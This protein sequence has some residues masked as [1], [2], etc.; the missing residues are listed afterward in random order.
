MSDKISNWYDAK[1]QNIFTVSH[2]SCNVDIVTEYRQLQQGKCV[3]G[4]GSDGSN[5]QVDALYGVISMQGGLLRT[6][7]KCGAQV[8][9]LVF[10]AFSYGTVVTFPKVSRY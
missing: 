10:R 8:T 9:F 4:F 1:L 7:Q 6:Q 5:D 2:R 3:K